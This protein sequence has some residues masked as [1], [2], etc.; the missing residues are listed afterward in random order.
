[1]NFAGLGLQ[2]WSVQQKENAGP[3][4]KFVAD[5][6]YHSKAVNVLRF[7]PSGQLLAS[8]GDGGEI[9]IWR[10][11]ESVEDQPIWKVLRT[12]VMH[13]RDV[14]DLAWSPDSA[15]L[16][17]GSVDNQC[18]I[19]KVSSGQAW[20]VLNEHLHYVQGVAWDP[21]GQ[22]VVS[23]SADR[24]CRIY[25]SQMIP[26]SR[27]TGK[28][29]FV[30]QHVLAKTDVAC[31]KLNAKT[32][33]DSSIVKAVPSK[34]HLFHD[35]T[36]PSFFRRPAWS[37]DASFLVVP[38]GIH[39]PFLEA[40]PSNI[41][42]IMSRDDLSRPAIHLPGPS[43]PVVAVRF[44]PLIFS[45]HP[46]VPQ[47]IPSNPVDP[48]FSLPYRLVF[49]V[50]TLDSLFI[51]DTQH[52][53]PIV[54]CAGLH[55]AAITD[56]AWSAD[57]QYVA[58]SSQDGYCS[59]LAFSDAELGVQMPSNEIPPHIASYLPEALLAKAKMTASE[60]AVT[61]EDVQLN[62]PDK[63]TSVTL[64]PRPLKHHRITPSAVTVDSPPSQLKLHHPTPCAAASDPPASPVEF[65]CIIPAGGTV[66]LSSS[67]SAAEL[68]HTTLNPC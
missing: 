12:L 32:H 7:S 54:V 21:A 16:M 59:L 13:Q 15:S 18:I 35:E 29:F 61:S 44:C 67:P 53:S 52:S 17:S 38:S 47:E 31:L 2:L 51:Y 60:I 14:L 56:I 20:Q 64:C 4:V 57:G 11:A 9:L 30:C 33:Q 66:D 8:G 55:Y 10:Q 39:R 19:W 24:T 68:H 58:V 48:S 25:S 22:F 36:L 26:T 63:D 41:S 5:L 65:Q 28:G 46:T 37:P 6:S 34:H 43:K 50:A 40:A 23:L 42:Y 49:A 62:L 45:L 3:T 27:G 1:M